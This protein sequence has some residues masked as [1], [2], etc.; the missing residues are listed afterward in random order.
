VSN[1]VLVV[2]AKRQAVTARE[3]SCLAREQPP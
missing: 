2:E 3:T 1:K